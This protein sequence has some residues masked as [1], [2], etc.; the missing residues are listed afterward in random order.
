MALTDAERKLLEEL[1]ANFAS[2]D[3]KLASKLAQPHR[4]IHPTKTVLG[5]IGF[6]L[7]LAGLVAGMS[8]G[9]PVSVAGFVVMLVC[10]ILVI[11]SW[12]LTAG[13]SPVMSTSTPT[14]GKSSATSFMDRMEKRW[15][16]RL[17]EP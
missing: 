7:G 4:H 2:Q 17:E 13:P 1:E 14:V 8:M 10:A 12:S 5:S 16:D 9:W 11:S 15:R 3:P 6:L